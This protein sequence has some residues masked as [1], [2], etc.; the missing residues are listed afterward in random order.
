MANPFTKPS[1]SGYNANPPANDGS[2]VSS[3]EINWDTH[4]NKIGDPI[5]D[6]VDSINNKVES[7]FADIA[8]NTVTAK[9]SAYTVQTSDRGALLSVTNTTTITLLAAATAGD[10]FFIGVRNNGSGTVTVDGDSSETING[11]TTVDLYPGACLL[12]VSNGS[13][14][15]GAFIHAQD[16]IVTPNATGGDQ[17]ADT[18]NASEYYRNGNKL[19]TVQSATSLSGSQTSLSIPS[20]AKKITLDINGMSTNGVGLPNITL[21]DSGGEENSGYNGT[22]TQL[23]SGPTINISNLSASFL[24]APESSWA[25]FSVAHGSYTLSLSDTNKW[26]LGGG[27]GYSNSAALNNTY[28]EKTLS[29]E[30]TTIFFNTTNTFDAGTVNAIIEF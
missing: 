4:I 9:S 16:R 5:K 8:F 21:G 2:E 18:V 29:A 24:I 25:D 10:G 7:A 26:T 22:S 12:I 19:T 11:S 27:V 30:L 28:G 14:W 20:G 6:Y 15:L 23:Q 1:I 13:A 3:N 17:G